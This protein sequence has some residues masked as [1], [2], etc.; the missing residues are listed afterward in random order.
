[1]AV[2]FDGS[3]QEVA[4]DPDAALRLYEEAFDAA[5]QAGLALNPVPVILTPQA[6]LVE[7]VRLSQQKALADE[8][9]KADED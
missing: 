7:L 4:I 6:K 9:G 1:M 8:G 5:C 2:A 3:T